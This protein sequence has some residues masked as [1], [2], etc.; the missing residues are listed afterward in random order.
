MKRF[1]SMLLALALLPL[2]ALCDEPLP[3][4]PDDVQAVFSVPEQT[5]ADFAASYAPESYGWWRQADG[6]TVLVLYC[7]GGILQLLTG[8]TDSLLDPMKGLTGASDLP[9]EVLG[10]EASLFAA[11][12]D[13]PG[14]PLLTVRGIQIGESRETVLSL[15]PQDSAL[16]EQNTEDG[17]FSF[18]EAVSF[19]FDTPDAPDEG[20]SYTLTF[21]MEAQAVAAMRLVYEKTAAA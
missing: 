11:Y 4:G 10:M 17:D 18:E 21:Y 13:A 9:D 7:T 12:W 15:F 2:A 16:C 19:T 14:F 5:V 20:G 1:L 6:D 8:D 3:F